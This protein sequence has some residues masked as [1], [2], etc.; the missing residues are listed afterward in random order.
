MAIPIT[1]LMNPTAAKDKKRKE[2]ARVS[3]SFDADL[4]ASFALQEL[5]D[6]HPT[7]PEWF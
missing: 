7:R 2:E 6:S 5:V 4:F 1:P 3:V